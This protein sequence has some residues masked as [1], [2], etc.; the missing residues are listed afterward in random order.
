MCIVPKFT[1]A[2]MFKAQLIVH[3]YE[4]MEP[5]IKVFDDLLPLKAFLSKCI[6]IIL[7]HFKEKY[8]Q[9][10]NI[11]M[12]MIYHPLCKKVATISSYR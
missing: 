11:I 1:P 6:L 4:I 2:M 3:N 7:E 10:P 9:L 8:L 5:I 12:L